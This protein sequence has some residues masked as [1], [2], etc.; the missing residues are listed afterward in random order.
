MYL[1]MELLT[2]GLRIMRELKYASA[3]PVSPAP[4]MQECHAVAASEWT[5]AVPAHEPKP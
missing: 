2:R 5:Q 1:A 3:W 4:W